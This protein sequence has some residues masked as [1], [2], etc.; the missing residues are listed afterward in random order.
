MEIEQ[1]GVFHINGPW[2]FI[3]LQ[4]LLRYAPPFWA[5]VVFPGTLFVALAG[6]QW[7]DDALRCCM[8]FYVLMFI[9]IIITLS[10]ITLLR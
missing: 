4:E 8:A 1:M 10:G 9:T 5:G 7:E 3:G 6:T 2:F